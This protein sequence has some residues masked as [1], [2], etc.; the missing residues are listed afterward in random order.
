MI[1]YLAG[2]FTPS[3]KYIKILVSWGYCSQFMEKIK[4]FQTTNQ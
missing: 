2:G 3:E 1:Y 4:M